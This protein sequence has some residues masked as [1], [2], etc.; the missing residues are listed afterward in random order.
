MPSVQQGLNLFFEGIG[1]GVRNIPVIGDVFKD[2]INMLGGFVRRNL[3]DELLTKEE[4]IQA[5]LARS[6]YMMPLGAT[7]AQQGM[8]SSMQQLLPSNRFR[9]RYSGTAG[10]L[11]H[12]PIPI[13]KGGYPDKQTTP[14]QPIKQDIMSLIPVSLPL[15]HNKHAFD[16]FWNPY[17]ISREP[18][19]NV[20]KTPDKYENLN[21]VSD[22][23]ENP[24]AAFAT[25]GF[26]KLNKNRRT[27]KIY[28]VVI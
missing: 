13:P 4:K 22:Q 16:T 24:N 6:G 9:Q 17:A 15:E 14:P 21:F 12:P 27:K 18:V 23:N 20:E 25:T 1:E 3:A 26:T 8:G 7:Q 5:G 11:F 10:D 19:I 2:Y 28:K